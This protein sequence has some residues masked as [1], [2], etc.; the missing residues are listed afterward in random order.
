MQPTEG[1]EIELLP[2]VLHEGESEGNTP[3]LDVHGSHEYD[4]EAK[5]KRH[6][7]DQHD[8]SDNETRNLQKQPRLDY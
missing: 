1:I 3:Q 7:D 5:R 6:V 2:D 4:I 8:Q